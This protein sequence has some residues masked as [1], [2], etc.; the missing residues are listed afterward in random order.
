[1]VTSYLN[2]FTQ[3]FWSH[4]FW[5]SWVSRHNQWLDHA[6][7]LTICSGP[8]HAPVTHPPTTQ[9]LDNYS[10]DE[11]GLIFIIHKAQVSE[12]TA[13]LRPTVCAKIKSSSVSLHAVAPPLPLSEKALFIMNMLFCCHCCCCCFMLWCGWLWIF[14]A[15]AAFH[16]HVSSSANCLL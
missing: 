8:P 14:R 15:V 16:L 12:E 10:Y 1:M 6:D 7:S 5:V 11:A 2:H 13:P 4:N 9:I 3:N